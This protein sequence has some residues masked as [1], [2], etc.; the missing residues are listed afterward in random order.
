MD[1]VIYRIAEPH[2]TKLTATTVSASGDVAS[3]MEVF[4]AGY[5]LG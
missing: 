2:R 5:P 4:T 1:V 3:G